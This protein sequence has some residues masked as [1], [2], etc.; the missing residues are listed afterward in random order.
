M[1]LRATSA[2]LAAFLAAALAFGAHALAAPQAPPFPQVVIKIAAVPAVN[3]ETDSEVSITTNGTV[4]VTLAS[5]VEVNV[6]LNV[7]ITNTYWAATITPMKGV[8]MGSGEIP[9]TV[10]VTVPGRSTLDSNAQIRVEANVSAYGVGRI[11]TNETAIPIKQYYGVALTAS[12][13]AS[14]EKFDATAGAETSFAFRLQNMGNGHDTFDIR[15]PNLGDL[16]SRGISV[17]VPSP[18]TNVGVRVT[19]N[20]NGRISLPANIALDNYTI[21]LQAVSTG[22]VAAGGSVEATTAKIARVV[23]PAPV[24]NGGGTGNNTTDGAPKPFLPGFEG[25]TLAG[26]LAVAAMVAGR[27]PRRPSPGAAYRGSLDPS[28][29][30]R[31]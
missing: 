19:V 21:E 10:N 17:D 4:N 26:A 20:V 23:P 13:Q 14:P 2:V 30:P 6:Y 25:P 16:Q 31:P 15:I 27:R 11:F 29:A 18:V 9:F 22:A 12:T 7:S 5:F 8:L 24:E 3:V 1:K 28:R